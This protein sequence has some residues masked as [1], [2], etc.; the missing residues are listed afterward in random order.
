MPV[1]F[2]PASEI[3][4]ALD[5]KSL[6][7]ALR[8]AFRMGASARPYQAPLRNRFYVE[9]VHADPTILLNMPSWQ[10][11]GDLGIKMVTV[12]T[13][14]ASRIHIDT[15]GGFSLVRVF[16][17]FMGAALVAASGAVAFGPDE[18]F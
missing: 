14:Y 9:N 16:G 11:D 1:R 15:N 8:R 7:E 4:I 17:E 10:V 13:D 12:N 2:V 5:Q 3:E 6:I 18:W